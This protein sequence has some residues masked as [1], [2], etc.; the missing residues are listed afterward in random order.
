MPDSCRSDGL[1]TEPVFYHMGRENTS[2]AL[3]PQC[4]ALR[5]VIYAIFTA[6]IAGAE[7]RYIPRMSMYF[8]TDYSEIVERME[9]VDPQAYARTRNYVNGAVS[10]LSPYIS[11]GV[12][13]TR[14][15]YLSL[16]ARGFDLNSAEKFISELAWRDYW[17]QVWIARGDEI[18]RDLLHAQPLAERSGIPEALVQAQTGIEAVDEAVRGLSETGYMHNHMRMYVASIA[19]TIARC[20]W[21]VPARWMHY[22]LLD[23]DWA[24]NALSWQWVAG[25]NS[26]KCYRANQENINK[27]CHSAQRNTFLDVSY[28]ALEDVA[29]PDV[30][31]PTAQLA[32]PVERLEIDPPQIDARLPTLVYTLYNLDPRWHEGEAYNRIFFIDTDLLE[33]YPMA[34]K[35]LD[36]AL[37]LAENVD[38]IQPFV[39]S[40]SDLRVHCGESVLHFRE[41]PTQGHYEGCTEPRPMLTDT[42]GYFRSFFKFWRLCSKRLLAEERVEL[43]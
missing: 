21:L 39:G 2:F 7:G 1:R 23:A 3:G 17:Q 27:F 42:T 13:S 8:P 5:S 26:N 9:A 15:V 22:H 37:R 43:A 6:S 14:Q 33:R 16:R 4:L 12:L 36:F 28:E 41:H 11:R 34:P 38:G 30:L 31:R 40:F 18:D 10:Y 24:S 25:A 32:L 29:M 20:H 35:V 19:C